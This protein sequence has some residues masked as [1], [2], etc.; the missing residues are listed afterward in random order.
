MGSCLV[1]GRNSIVQHAPRL[2]RPGRGACGRLT[3]GNG[4]LAGGSADVRYWVVAHARGRGVASGALCVL[5]GW[6]LSDLGLHRVELEH[7][8]KNAASC[9]VAEKAGY[10]LEGTLRCRVLHEDGWHDMHLHAH[11]DRAHD[12]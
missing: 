4:S 8:R 11:L 10:L 6:A 7:S 3:L 9:R 5:T 1:L 2:S 12:R